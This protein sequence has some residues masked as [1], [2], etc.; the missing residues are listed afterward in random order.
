MPIA[1]LLLLPLVEIFLLIISQVILTSI[2]RQ[3][4]CSTC[5]HWDASKEKTSM[6]YNFNLKEA[7]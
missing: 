5:I 6:V 4:V 2:N 1:H 7:A 3:A